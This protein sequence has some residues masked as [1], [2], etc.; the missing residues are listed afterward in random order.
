MNN[1]FSHLAKTMS[2]YPTTKTMS[3]APIFA[4][5]FYYYYSLPCTKYA[6]KSV[7]QS[8]TIVHPSTHNQG[9]QNC[10]PTRGIE[11]FCD[12]AT[13]WR[14]GI[15]AENCRNGGIVLFTN[16]SYLP[17]N[18]RLSNSFFLHVFLSI[19]IPWTVRITH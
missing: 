5:L 10:N 14:A 2:L 9:S 18:S 16:S 7:S 13:P 8:C 4:C 6:I 1:T 11:W 17:W 15:A 19:I 3:P 12:L